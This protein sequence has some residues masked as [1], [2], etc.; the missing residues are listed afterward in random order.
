MSKHSLSE[1]ANAARFSPREFLRARRPELF[2]DSVDEP[3]SEVDRSLLEYHVETLTNRS[4]ELDF[5]RF[6][7]R[8]CELEICPNLLPHT[9]PTG[10][11]D[12]KVDAET[13]PVSDALAFAWFAGNGSASERWAFAFS[14]KADWRSKVNSDVA[15]IATTGRNYR[16]VFFVS[17]RYIRDRERAEVEDT[18]SKKH[19]VDV[20]IL[21]RSWILD[22][23][24]AGHHERLAIN[25]LKV[26]ALTGTRRVRG[27]RDAEAE[28]AR[29]EIEARII[30]PG[31]KFSEC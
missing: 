10:G 8:L 11:G 3:V 27:P 12:S 22:R 7:R 26:T 1:A 9:G 21:D 16:K 31:I 13:C 14:A 24:S 15:G 6:A 28:K 30:L 17:S 2:S 19:G 29:E 25:E 5:E 4:Q 20:R 18:L 23:V